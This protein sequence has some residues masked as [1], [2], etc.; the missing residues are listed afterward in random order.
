MSM[1]VYYTDN[2]VK[3]ERS[4]PNLDAQTGWGRAS[5]IFKYILQGRTRH[6]SIAFYYVRSIIVDVLF[7][8]RLLTCVSIPIQCTDPLL[9]NYSLCPFLE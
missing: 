6:D 1:Y 2:D 8:Y 9:Q 7:F 4:S 3:I 5:T